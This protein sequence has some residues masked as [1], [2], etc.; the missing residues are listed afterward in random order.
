MLSKTKR[1]LL[2]EDDIFLR[3][4]TGRMLKKAGYDVE[5]AGD[6]AEA[7]ELFRSERDAGRPFD[8][9]I[10][11]LTVSDGMGGSD[12]I[13]KIR[14]VD[15]DIKAIVSSGH[16]GSTVLFR[17]REYGFHGVLRKP[18]EMNELIETVRQVLAGNSR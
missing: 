5:T 15:P 16:A 17:F 14:G 9:V 18:Y 8:V 11:D 10:L 4:V 3:D 12:A 6:G 2:M 7:V 1:I 13:E